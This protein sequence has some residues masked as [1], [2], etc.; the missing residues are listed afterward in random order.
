MNDEYGID[1]EEVCPH[2]QGTG[3]EPIWS[4]TKGT[5]GECE[6]M[7]YIPLIS[8]YHFHDFCCPV[9]VFFH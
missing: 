4:R 1:L 9:A 6:G 7:G 3:W 2:C 8:E 5:C